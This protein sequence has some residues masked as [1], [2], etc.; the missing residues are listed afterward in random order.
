MALVMIPPRAS[1]AAEVKLFLPHEATR[2]RANCGWTKMDAVT[3]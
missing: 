1:A 3:K 2:A